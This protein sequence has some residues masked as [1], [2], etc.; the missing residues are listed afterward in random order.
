MGN[1]LIIQD[2]VLG[3]KLKMWESDNVRFVSIQLIN[4]YSICLK[5]WYRK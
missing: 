2:M 3:E 4:T 5:S 1:Q